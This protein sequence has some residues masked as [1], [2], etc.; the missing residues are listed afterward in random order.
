MKVT[1]AY[2]VDMN[3]PAE[4]LWALARNSGQYLLASQWESTKAVPGTKKGRVCGPSMQ[5]TQSELI[6]NPSVLPGSGHCGR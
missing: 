4:L 6:G 3:S 5:L 2:S 1:G